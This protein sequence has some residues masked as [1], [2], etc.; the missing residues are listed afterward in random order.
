MNSKIE[1]YTCVRGFSWRTFLDW[2]ILDRDHNKYKQISIDKSSKYVVMESDN[3]DG[4]LILLP[5]KN[6][7]EG[8]KIYI[9]G[10]K[11]IVIDE[12]DL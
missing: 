8:Y 9:D 10:E 7:V 2:Y 6:V 12:C 11:K 5:N 1:F 4:V 3:K